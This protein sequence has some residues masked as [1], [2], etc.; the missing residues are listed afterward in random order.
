MISKL[1]L[2]RIGLVRILMSG[3]SQV[4]LLLVL[5]LLNVLEFVVVT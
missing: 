3:T 4:H 2:L 5:S 1:L